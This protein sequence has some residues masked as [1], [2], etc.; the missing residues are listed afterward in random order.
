MR[1]GLKANEVTKIIEA[2]DDGIETEQ[3]L[4]G[5]ELLIGRGSLRARDTANMDCLNAEE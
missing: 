3:L 2:R 1:K 5:R 4:I